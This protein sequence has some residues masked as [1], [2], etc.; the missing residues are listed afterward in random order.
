MLEEENPAKAAFV[1][2][3]A[4]V[5]E[6]G[7]GSI[8]EALGRAY[9]KCARYRAAADR[10]GEALLVDPANDYAHY[11][12]G[13]ACLKLGREA[14]AAGHFKVAWALAPREVYREK[15]VR[16]NAPGAAQ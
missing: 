4:R 16:F 7:K 13:L 9:Y 2:E 5:I 1:L 14:E 12:L 11:C 15:A 8:L 10:F 3:K 6:P